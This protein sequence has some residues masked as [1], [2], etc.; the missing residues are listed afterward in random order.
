MFFVE[1]E[2][3]GV[4]RPTGLQAKLYTA[5]FSELHQITV[6]I[7]LMDLYND[8]NIILAVSDFLRKNTKNGCLA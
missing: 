3:V 2:I 7:A 1:A 8:S 6:D 4:R 5:L